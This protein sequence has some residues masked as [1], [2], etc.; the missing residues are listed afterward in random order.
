MGESDARGG[1]GKVASDRGEREDGA[2]DEIRRRGDAVGRWR[3]GA[4]GETRCG[5]R[6]IPARAWAHV[7]RERGRPRR[8]RRG[9][10]R[11]RLVEQGT[12]V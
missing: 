8:V 9:D 1:G 5:R 7:L 6:M 10:E 12:D 2:R 4:V 11:R 3:D